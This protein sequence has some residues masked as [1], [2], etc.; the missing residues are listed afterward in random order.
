MIGLLSKFWIEDRENTTSPGVRQ[1]YGMLCSVVGIILNLILFL[2][3]FLA[4]TIGNSISIMADAFNN[5]SDAGSSFITLI[6]FKMSVQEADPNHPFGHGR[7]EY[8]SGL[9]VAGA[10]LLMGYELIVSSAKK[11]LQPEETTFSLLTLTILLSS[12]L[13]K[14]YMAYYN[15]S[16]G[17]K[18]TSS[19]LK[20]TATDSLS[21]AVTTTAVLLSS[22]FEHFFHWRLDGYCGVLVGLFIIYAGFNAARDTVNPLL[23]QPPAREFVEQVQQ[24]V[25][26][27]EGILGM[28]DL[29][30]HDYGPGRVIISLHAEVSSTENLLE[31]HDRIDGLERT[32]NRQLHCEAVIHM[33][34]VILEDPDILLWQDRINSILYSIDPAFHIHDFR[35]IKESTHRKLIFD[36]V[37]PHNCKMSKSLLLEEIQNRVWTFDKNYDVV[38]QMEHSYI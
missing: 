33:D 34:P 14:F 29:I 31:I 38:I 7:I 25:L 35:I 13:V 27:T 12:I 28:H 20:A 5:L 9:V 10:I 19:S 1:S 11:I 17:K 2:G 8:L 26:N 6:G 23:G 15:F 4:G 16:I 24:I 37:L 30:V 32:L 22:L 21:D 18:I 3:K 36:L